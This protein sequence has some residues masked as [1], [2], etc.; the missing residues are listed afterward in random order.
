MDKEALTNKVKLILMQMINC[1][2][3]TTFEAIL[4]KIKPVEIR[5]LLKRF[6]F[7]VKKRIF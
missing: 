4:L 7:H 5:Y 1:Q 2:F 3:C 6:S